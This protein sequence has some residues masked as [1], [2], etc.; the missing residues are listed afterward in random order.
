[1][2][3]RYEQNKLKKL[4]KKLKPY[5]ISKHD[6]EAGY[7]IESYQKYKDIFKKIYIEVKGISTSDYSFYLSSNESL[8]AE[9]HKKDYYL[10]LIP[11][12]FSKPEKFD[13]SKMIKINNI[14]KNILA[15][16]KVWKATSSTFL[17]KKI[18]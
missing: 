18:N 6:V 16:T 4:D 1:M 11:R 12:D 17:I 15:N 8:V 2:V 3:F 5:H 7:D 9:K 10:Y 13:L 14:N